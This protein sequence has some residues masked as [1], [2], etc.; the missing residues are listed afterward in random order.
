MLADSFIKAHAGAKK[1]QAR[2]ADIFRILQGE[3]ELLCEF[4]TRFQKER[5]LLPVVPYEWVAE[6]FTKG[7]NPR[8]SDAFRKL[9]ESLLKFQ[10]T[11]WVDVHNRYESKIRIE[12]DQLGF[13]ASTEGRDRE[14]NR[15]KLKDDFDRDPN[16][17][18]QYHGTNDYRTVDCQNLCEDVATL[19]KNGHL[20][21]FLSDWAKNNYSYSQD[22]A[23]PSKIGEDSL[24]QNINM[25]FGGNEINGVTFSVEKMIK[26]SVAHSKRLRT[27]AED[28]I[29]FTEEDADGILVPHNGALVISLN[30]LDFKIKRILVDPESSTN[31]IQWMVL[32]QAKLT[33]SIIPATK[34][35]AGFNLASV[36]TRGEILLPNNAGWVMKTTLFDVLDREMGYN[37]ILCRTWLHEMKVHFSV[38]GKMPSLLLTS[39]EKN[40]FERTPECQ[41][42]LK[43]LKQYLSSP[44]LLS[45][46]EE[47]KQ[48]LIY[49]AVLEI[50]DL[51]WPGGLDS[52]VIEIKCDSQLVVNQVYGI[53][54]TKEECM[55]QYV[56]KVMVQGMVHHPHPERRK[57]RSRCIGQ[58]GLV[59]EK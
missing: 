6:A 27:V 45:K 29:T 9:K 7:L 3:F 59:Q 16:L 53:F 41:R 11:I 14:K 48:L 4:V 40:N 30:I 38:L 56:L 26:V 8:S 22:N 51:N 15:D 33:G 46:S 55:Q 34:L 54:D 18:C 42:A 24:L 52:E 37:I 28:D 13:S 57:C 43:D 20:R 12:N 21:E 44:P 50:A 19:L 31:I 39:E 1:V 25:I 17:W 2:N 36:T 10:A 49:L 23:E 5:M 35:L 32:E 47:G 58:F